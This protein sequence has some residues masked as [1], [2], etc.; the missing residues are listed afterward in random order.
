MLL[1]IGHVDNI[2]FISM[3]I[4]LSLYYD[5]SLFVYHFCYFLFLVIFAIIMFL[6]LLFSIY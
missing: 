1:L 5:C 2:L 6:L 4:S 3:F